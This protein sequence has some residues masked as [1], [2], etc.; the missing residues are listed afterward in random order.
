[1]SESRVETLRNE[2]RERERTAERES[3][4]R[5]LAV[6]TKKRRGAGSSSEERVRRS[7]SLQGTGTRGSSKPE[8]GLDGW[9]GRRP[10]DGRTNRVDSKKRRRAAA[11]GA[12]RRGRSAKVRRDESECGSAIVAVVG[13]TQG[14]ARRLRRRTREYSAAER[15]ARN[16]GRAKPRTRWRGCDDYYEHARGPSGR[17][18]R[19]RADSG[20]RGPARS[21]DDGGGDAGLR[22]RGPDHGAGDHSGAARR[23]AARQPANAPG[24]GV[25]Q[26]RRDNNSGQGVM[27]STKLDDTMDSNGFWI[28]DLH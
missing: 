16:D 23:R 14:A 11:R 6:Q 2:E 5:R 1:M 7:S 8:G 18:P 17:T 28:G 19:E 10:S 21:R 25:E 20:S 27:T 4:R 9:F 13:S 12:A 3:E 15:A 24:N 22:T 26:R